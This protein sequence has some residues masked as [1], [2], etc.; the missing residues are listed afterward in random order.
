MARLIIIKGKTDED[1][2]NLINDAM[3]DDL[4]FEVDLQSNALFMTDLEL[5][6]KG[7]K[8]IQK[9]L[10]RGTISAKGRWIPYYLDMMPVYGGSYKD[11]VRKLIR[12]SSLGD[13][14]DTLLYLDKYHRTG[15]PYRINVTDMSHR[16]LLSAIPVY[17]RDT[18][19]KPT[20]IFYIVKFYLMHPKE[21]QIEL[22]PQVPFTIQGGQ[23]D[24]YNQYNQDRLNLFRDVLIHLTDFS[25]PIKKVDWMY[26]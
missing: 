12:T 22:S 19:Y 20:E 7:S 15:R 14:L 21:V 24:Y 23:D 18:S 3:E 13:P 5:I 11:D 10:S 17:I 1:L 6:T 2:V 4:K 8:N 25:Y 26:I 16:T 9:S